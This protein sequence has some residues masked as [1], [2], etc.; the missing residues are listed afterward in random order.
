[1]FQVFLLLLDGE[2]FCVELQDST[3]VI[4]TEIPSSNRK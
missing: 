3:D 2:L 4:Y 1:M